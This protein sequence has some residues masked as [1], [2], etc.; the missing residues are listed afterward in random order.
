M[1]NKVLLYFF[2]MKVKLLKIQSLIC[3]GPCCI[4]FKLH[5]QFIIF[6]FCCI[7]IKMLI[8]DIFTN[9]HSKIS[10]LVVLLCLRSW[11]NHFQIKISQIHM[12]KQNNFAILNKSKDL[13]RKNTV[14]C[15]CKNLECLNSPISNYIF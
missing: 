4:F 10:S 9:V 14:K 15:P 11:T 2:R 3:N 12:E 13:M 7:L 5:Y 6:F 1:K 8:F